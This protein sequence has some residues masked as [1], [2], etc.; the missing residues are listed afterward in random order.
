MDPKAM[1]ERQLRSARLIG[2]LFYELDDPRRVRQ[3]GDSRRNVILR[4]I[5]DEADA[6]AGAVLDFHEFRGAGGADPYA[7]ESRQGS[8]DDL[9]Q[10]L[11]E[12]LDDALGLYEIQI[13][14]RR[15]L[16]LDHYEE[17]KKDVEALRERL[18]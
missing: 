16:G 12:V 17:L 7:E 9:P 10:N 3:G 1:M 8:V 11:R 2:E 18:L 15:Y 4:Q 14:K 6:L 13:G 5:A